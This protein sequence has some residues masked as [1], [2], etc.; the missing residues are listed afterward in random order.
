LEVPEGYLDV[1]V[2]LGF[3]KPDERRHEEKIVTALDKF[4][5]RHLPQPSYSRAH[6]P[7]V[8]TV[9]VPVQETGRGGLII[10]HGPRR[11]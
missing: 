11:W 1:L 5:R 3:L 4:V 9:G 2:E 6:L 10:H 8:G 7:M